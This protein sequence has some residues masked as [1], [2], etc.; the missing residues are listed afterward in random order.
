MDGGRENV[1]SP[2]ENWPCLGNGER[3]GL[4]LT[5]NRKS[6]MPRQT[7]SVLSNLFDT[8]GNLVNF[9]PAGGLQSRGAMASVRSTSL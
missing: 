3:Y 4:G 6:H 9:P 2:T 8:V 7:R 1:R 5:T